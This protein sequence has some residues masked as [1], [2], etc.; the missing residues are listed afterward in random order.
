MTSSTVPGTWSSSENKVSFE[1]RNWYGKGDGV[2]KYGG[3][4]GREGEFDL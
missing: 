2:L 3:G 1:F 4:S